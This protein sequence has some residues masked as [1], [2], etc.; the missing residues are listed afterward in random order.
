MNRVLASALRA[1]VAAAIPV[2]VGIGSI[3]DLDGGKAL[4]ITAIV[5]GGAAALR[6]LQTAV[7]SLTTAS[8]VGDQYAAYLDSFL[9]AALSSLAVFAIGILSAP[10]LSVTSAA[11]VAAVTGAIAAGIRALEALLPPPEPTPV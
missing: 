3:P 4:V 7:P 2:L 10:E 11:V 1:F 9:R 8:L 6:V 5:A